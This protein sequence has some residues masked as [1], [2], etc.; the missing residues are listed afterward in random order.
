[1]QANNASEA[2]TGVCDAFDLVAETQSDRFRYLD[3]LVEFEDESCIVSNDPGF[4][5]EVT[6]RA[7]NIAACYLL[8]DDTADAN[9]NYYIHIKNA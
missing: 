9:C 4:E 3:N 5:D 7:H 8:D 6:T 1:M 2:S